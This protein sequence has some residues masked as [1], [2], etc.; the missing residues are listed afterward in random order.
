MSAF[1]T[2]LKALLSASV[3]R[4]KVCVC[5]T[6]WSE[7]L[8]RPTVVPG[9]LFSAMLAALSVTAPGESLMLVTVTL[10]LCE[11]SKRPKPESMAVTVT[12]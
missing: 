7:V 4:L 9:G 8:S 3:P 6:S 1:P 5:P 2:I 10:K 11:T 12:S